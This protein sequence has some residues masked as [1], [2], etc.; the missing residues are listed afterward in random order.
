LHSGFF[1]S[2]YFDLIIAFLLLFDIIKIIKLSL[3][4]KEKQMENIITHQHDHFIVA[5]FSDSPLTHAVYH[6]KIKE[7][8]TFAVFTSF[9]EKPIAMKL[10]CAIT[11]YFDKE[12]LLIN[13]ME[14]IYAS[15]EFKSLQ[16]NSQQFYDEY[17]KEHSHCACDQPSFAMDNHILVAADLEKPNLPRSNS[18]YMIFKGMCSVCE[19]SLTLG[20]PFASYNKIGKEQLLQALQIK[21]DDLRYGKKVKLKKIITSRAQMSSLAKFHR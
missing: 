10:R 2:I 4:L 7:G 3:V 19:K 15:K 18:R 20:I 12:I 16:L 6:D 1:L 5:E 17:S 8:D 21:L 11:D 14:S 13:V 9:Q